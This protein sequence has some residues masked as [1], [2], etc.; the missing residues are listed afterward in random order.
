MTHTIYTFGYSRHT[1]AELMDLVTAENIAVVADVRQSPRSRWGQ[2]DG[3]YLKRALGRRYRWIRALGNVNRSPELPD[4]VDERKGLDELH[5]I[6]QTHGS[7][8]L[9]CLERDP[10]CCHRSYVAARMEERLPG[11]RVVH[12]GV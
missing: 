7:V 6:L 3:T 11:V 4:L 10:H 2:W 12:L 8:L 9:L 5:E 1:L